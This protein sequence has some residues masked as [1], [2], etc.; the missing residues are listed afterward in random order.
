M[1]DGG[2]S[3]RRPGAGVGGGWVGGVGSV[4][5]RFEGRCAAGF[6]ELAYVCRTAAEVS[7]MAVHK[8]GPHPGEPA[9][10]GDGLCVRS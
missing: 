7:G 1:D 10:D 4:R 6:G 9:C 8:Y 5:Q 3:A 2:A